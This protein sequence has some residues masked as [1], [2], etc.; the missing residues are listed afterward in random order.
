LLIGPGTFSTAA[1]FAA[2]IKDLG[3]G[4]IVGEETGGLASSYGDVFS[5]ELPN[6][7]LDLG[8]SYKY[9]LRTGGFD[10]GRGV[11]P[12]IRIEAAQIKRVEGKD[13][14]L[15]SLLE[16]IDGESGG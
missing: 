4:T 13:P 3:V 9:F 7:E 2:T 12:D 5:V 11:I 16:K 1:D 6:S 8:I 15:S 10:N 14:V